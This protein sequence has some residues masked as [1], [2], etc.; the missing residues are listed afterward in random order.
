MSLSKVFIIREASCPLCKTEGSAGAT[1]FYCPNPRCRNFDK[2]EQEAR[3]KKEPSNIMKFE[4]LVGQLH[5]VITQVWNL[6]F[7]TYSNAV[8]ELVQA[9][10]EKRNLLGGGANWDMNKLSWDFGESKDFVVVS[11]VEPEEATVIFVLNK[12]SPSKWKIA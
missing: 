12:A 3:Q 7:A 1:S 6:D 4:D 8:G 10:R 11:P 2:K 9:Y 5:R